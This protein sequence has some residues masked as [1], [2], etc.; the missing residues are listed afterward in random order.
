MGEPVHFSVNAKGR[1]M[2]LRRAPGNIWKVGHATGDM[3]EK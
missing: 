3:E 2:Q 1:E